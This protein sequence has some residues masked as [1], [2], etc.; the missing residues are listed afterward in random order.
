MSAATTPAAP[1]VLA[2]D[3]VRVRF[4]GLTALEDVSLTVP[5]AGIV[6][7]VGPNGAGKTT[8]FNVL[9]GLQRPTSGRVTIGGD[10]VTDATPQRRARRGLARTFQRLELFGE[11][12]VREHLVVAYR[13]SRGG[14]VFL[15]DFIGLG[16]HASAEEDAVVDGLLEALGLA[17]VA[18]RAAVSLP[19]GMGRLVEVGRALATDPSVVLLDEPSSGLNATETD[20]L[21]NSLRRTRDERGVALVVVEHNV[22]L[23]LG[24]SDRITV[25]DFGKVI[26][27]GR[28]SEIRVDPAVQA[29]YLGTEVTT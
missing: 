7:L 15:L 3:A 18:G 26:A 9:S 17:G 11:L 4:G 14:S 8:L 12:T 22:D 21:A 28:P 25:L 1:P 24:L 29:A 16:R 20:R 23:V 6:G 27:E 2:A 10:D 19:L 13:S 5:A